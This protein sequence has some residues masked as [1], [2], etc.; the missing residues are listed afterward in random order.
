[1]SVPEPEQRLAALEGVPVTLLPVRL[2]T[3]FVT[4]PN[5]Q[6]PTE[7]RIRV[8]PD[9]VHVDAHEPRLTPAEVAAGQVYWR[10]RWNPQT[11]PRAWEE[12][13]RGIRPTRAAW[14]V[15]TLT[16]TN[17]V[18]TAPGPKFPPTATRDPQLD[19][20]LALRAMPT[21][22]VALGYDA[23]GVQVLRRW[24]DK[25]VP[26]GLRATAPLTAGA[27][28]EGDAAIS[29]YLG[30]AA[31]YDAAVASGMAVTVT[32]ADLPQGRSVADGIDRIVVLGVN[33]T[34]GAAGGASELSTLLAAHEVTDGLGYLKP[35][36]PTNNLAAG[37]AA[38][39][40]VDVS[41]PAAPVPILDAKWSAAARIASA[42]GID[43]GALARVPGA[44][45]TNARVAADLVDATWGGSL[46]YFADQLLSPLLDDADLTSTREHAVRHLRPLGPLPTLRVGR[47]PLG[48]L[49]V[50][51]PTATPADPFAARLA[52]VLRKIR[53]MWEAG[54]PHVPRVVRSDGAG[55]QVEQ[56]LLGILRRA[57]WTTRI[58]YRRVYGPL[59]ALTATGVGVALAQRFQS[60]LRNIGFLDSFGLAVQPRIVPFSIHDRTGH[61]RIPFLGA[62]EDGKQPD[63]GYLEELRALTFRPDA[64]L[65]L[66]RGRGRSVL[67]ALARFAAQQELD[68][69]AARFGRRL[70]GMTGPTAWRTTEISG[71]GARTEP[72][73]LE[74]STRRFAELGDRTLAE[75]VAERLKAS[76]SDAR[77]GDLKA[78]QTALGR[79]AKSDPAD[80]DPAFR[81]YLGACSH[82]LDAWLTSLAGS[83]LESLRAERPAGTHLG[84]FGYV[85]GLRPEQAPDSLGYVLGPSVAHASTA[86]ILR[87]GYLGQAARSL[88][89]DLSSERVEG[90]LEVMRGVVEGVPLSVL[91]GY[92]IERALRD[93]GLSVLILPLRTVF[94]LRTPPP[95]ETPG[96]PAESTPP[97]N[98]TDAVELLERWAAA[99]ADVLQK[100]RAAAKLPAGD[101][102]L[103]AFAA[104]VDVLAD[105]WDAIADLVLAEAVHQIVR[106]QPE[107]AQ[108]ATRFLDRQEPPVEP[109]VA[110]TPRTATAYVQRCAVA[111]SATAPSA[112][113][114]PLADARSAAEPRLNAW[115]AALLGAPT[116]WRFSGRAIGADGTPGATAVVG[117]VDLKLS[118]L[119]LV[120]TTES[121][122]SD[123][124]TELEERIARQLAVKLKPGPGGGVEL[125]AETPN[126]LGLAAFTALASAARR[127]LRAARPADARV[128]DLPD[129]VAAPGLDAA[130]LKRRADAAAAALRSA[131]PL[132]D[133]AIAAPTQAKLTTAFERVS[134]LGVGGAVPPLG[135]LPGGTTPVAPE[136][137]DLAR[138]AAAAAHA[139]LARLT[140]LEAVTPAPPAAAAHH[141]QRIA[142]V[143][144]DAFPALGAF[145]LAATTAAA[146][147]L[148]PAGQT[149][150]LR[151]DK[152]APVT[153]ITR[154][155]RVRPELDA[156]WHLLVAAEAATGYDAGAF[157]VAQ[158]PFAAGDAWAA[159]PFDDKRPTARAAVALHAPGGFRSPTAAFTV[160][161][162]T[163]QIPL[164]EETVG[165]SFHY[166]APSNRAPQTAI[167]AVPPQLTERPWSLDAIADTVREAFDLARIRGV[168]LHDVPAV[169]SVLPALY[170][171][172]DPGGNVPSVDLDRLADVLGPAT[173]VLGK[174]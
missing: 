48:I 79:L 75:E 103:T 82:R 101:P 173:L 124:P 80:V 88:D 155:A 73:P 146:K 81:A 89:V 104:Q 147:S 171:P 169:G 16:P 64:R 7:L 174:D 50:L 105:A 161:T 108:A 133:A 135:L 53:P 67:D 5:A 35:G 74:L 172:L 84:G 90:A 66:A 145:T 52:D 121:G 57:P 107:R 83:Q 138:D 114:Q 129:G 30:W 51:A 93:A 24:F 102:S 154:M 27:L 29:A 69:A 164:P 95:P 18:G 2:E 141:Q 28:L 109:D 21:R 47:Q 152:L 119:S 6:A 96:G 115:L 134:R 91:L 12:L 163:E 132:L 111:L 143:F 77:L 54:V 78:L 112:A 36:T 1:V 43:P 55:G 46:G 130:D 23:S 42:L 170:L 126:A 167:V 37:P 98:V 157:A 100:V 142:T 165:M 85:E 62:S 120:V 26:A 131:V 49:P 41:D 22:W 158:A 92:R 39:G 13:I 68:L 137:L 40:A 32:Q 153:W 117:P 150:L 160:D 4:P 58:W 136:A 25:P 151:G 71:I 19:I 86:G 34:A 168:G 38:G 10:N 122:S 118:P 61:L 159:L 106:G 45:E 44:A 127:V 166:D 70:L 162:W 17:P 125:L 128:F 20:P 14:I 156:L 116:R 110:A 139:R 97:N 99:R 33:W 59:I 3:R 60:V 140:E 15:R 94:P 149:S 148:L 123:Q 56:L 144:G 87:S 11:A 9:Q 31:D 8:Y 65:E 76:S 63:L 113:W 72:S